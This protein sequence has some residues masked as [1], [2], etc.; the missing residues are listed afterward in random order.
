MRCRPES[1][2]K[3]S[4]DLSFFRPWGGNVPRPRRTRSSR[5][6]W[7]SGL[8]RLKIRS[9]SSD[10]D[11]SK[12]TLSGSAL[13]EPTPFGECRQRLGPAGSE[14]PSS[15]LQALLDVRR[16]LPQQIRQ[17][18]VRD[19]DE[20]GA[21]STALGDENDTVPGNLL[22]QLFGVRL[23]SCGIDSGGRHGSLLAVD[24][25][26]LRRNRP[27]FGDGV[28]RCEGDAMG[29]EGRETGGAGRQREWL[30]IND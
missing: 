5:I 15:G 4:N 18:V 6:R 20:R 14:F 3:A 17:R 22:Q 11:G 19:R 26:T 28:S 9:R 1:S 16:V 23:Q 27:M 29:G 8:L 24:T 10:A 2:W 7:S 13:G 12:T 30:A 25:T 21:G